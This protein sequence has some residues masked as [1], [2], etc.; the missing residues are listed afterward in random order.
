MV[1]NRSAYTT[2]MGAWSETGRLPY[3]KA[4][5]IKT[6]FR[7]RETQRPMGLKV[8]QDI[9][10]PVDYLEWRIVVASMR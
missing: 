5:P 3:D 8:H 4:I 10:K 1:G 6:D 9:V 2:Q 7:V